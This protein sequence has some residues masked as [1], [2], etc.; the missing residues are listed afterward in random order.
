MFFSIVLGLGLW[1]WFSKEEIPMAV[2]QLVLSETTTQRPDQLDLAPH[3]ISIEGIRQTPIEPTTL[4]IDRQY[5]QR[6]NYTGYL[7][8]YQSQGLK[9]N[10]LL[11]VPT[12]TPPT[13][14]FPAIVFLHGYIPPDQYQTTQKYEAYVDYLASHGFVVLK[15]DYRGHGDSEGEA[16]GAYFSQNYVLDTLAAIKALQSYDQVNPDAIG[17]WGHSMSGNI[18]FRTAVT[19]PDVKAVVIWAGAVYTYEDR[20]RYGLNDNS[21]VRNRGESG[22]IFSRSRALFEEH[23]EFSVD[24]PFWQAM[25]PTNYL[26]YLTAPT[27]LHHAENDT[28]VNVG[29]SQDLVSLL[30]PAGKEIE[31]FTYASGGH[32]ITG[33]A[34]SQAMQRTVAFFD[35]QLTL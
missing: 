28:V 29:Y 27:Q 7:S 31:L 22:R 26:E 20:E 30:E 34:F 17:L 11:T 3:P 15:I 14:G 16:S 4:E 35:Q 25:V 12:E 13:N 5:Q 33:S 8:H 18:A 19:S 2:D 9:I 23:G 24:N 1:F 10:A 32:N 6:P 21:F